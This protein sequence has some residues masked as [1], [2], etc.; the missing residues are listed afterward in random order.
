MKMAAASVFSALRAEFEAAQKGLKDVDENIKRLTGRDPDEF[1]AQLRRPGGPMLGGPPDQQ[2]RERFS[3]KPE[4]KGGPPTTK[5][6]NFGGPFVRPPIEPPPAEES[7]DEE[8]LPR[9]GGVQSWVVAAPTK[10]TQRTRKEASADQ[11]GDRRCMERNKRMFGIMLGTLQKFQSEETRRKDQLQSQKRAEIEQK[12]EEAAEREKAQLRKERQDL[13]LS[14]RQKQQSLRRLELKMEVARLHEEAEARQRLLLNF[15]HTRTKPH[16]M[17]KPAKP[18]PETQKRLK[19]SQKRI[20]EEEEE[21]SHK[22][23]RGPPATETSA[24]EAS[25]DDPGHRVKPEG[26]NAATDSEAVAPGDVA[27]ATDAAE[28]M[29]VGGEETA[30]QQTGPWKGNVGITLLILGEGRAQ[31]ALQVTSVVRFGRWPHVVWPLVE[32]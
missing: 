15:I 32:R 19:E 4:I 20:L 25:T 17:F 24:A 13:F 26:E 22:E 18:C 23:N 10:E 5:R 16:I 8:D 14:R 9:K 27:A 6:R 30:G 31:K 7:G 29:E 12:L 28:P 2:G 3:G 11:K 1:R 21:E